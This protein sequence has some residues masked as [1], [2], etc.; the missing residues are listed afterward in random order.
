MVP[1]ATDEPELA[2][3]AVHLLACCTTTPVPAQSRVRNR[4]LGDMMAFCAGPGFFLFGRP[5]AT[6]PLFFFLSPSKE[7]RFNS[8][9]F[10]PLRIVFG[11][12][13]HKKLACWAMT[14]PSTCIQL[15]RDEKRK[16]VAIFPFGCRP[17]PQVPTAI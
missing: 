3:L 2:A 17:G 4:S 15:L 14:S 16:H 6:P 1:C 5:H 8:S 7:R 12:Q 9:L 13:A 11:M 10:F